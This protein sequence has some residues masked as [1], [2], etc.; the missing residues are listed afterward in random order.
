MTR[1]TIPVMERL[2]AKVIKTSD[3]WIFNG[4]ITGGSKGGYG[5]IREGGRGSPMKRVHILVYESINGAVPEGLQV[6]HTCD[7][8]KCCNPAHLFLGT[9]KDNI[10]DMIKKGRKFLTYGETGNYKL[11]NDQVKAIRLDS[12]SLSI[13]AKDYG[14]CK[15]NISM[16]KNFKSRRYN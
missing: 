15:S 7:N 8:R 3:C 14:T 11:T 12:R 6:C 4:S 10:Q 13:I 9:A 16:I 5:H 2:W 1:K